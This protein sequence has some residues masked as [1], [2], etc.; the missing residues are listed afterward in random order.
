[1]GDGLSA[2]AAGLA[3]NA[4]KKTNNQNPQIQ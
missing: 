3:S 4:F 1:L 2:V